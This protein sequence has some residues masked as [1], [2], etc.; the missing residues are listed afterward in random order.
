MSSFPIEPRV[1]SSWAKAQGFAY[2]FAYHGPSM[3]P[4]FRSGDLLYLR[5]G[6]KNLLPGDVI[7]FTASKES[8]YIVH[9]IV[10]RSDQGFI[11]RGDHNRLPDTSQ[12]TLEQV[13]GKVEFVENKQ[14]VRRVVNGFWGLW[15]ARF[16][17]LVFGLD[18]L[19]RRLFWVPYNFIRTRQIALVFWRPKISKMRVQ[20]ENGQQIKYLYNN[21]TVAVWDLSRQ[22]FDCRKPFDLVIPS[23]LNEKRSS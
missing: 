15:L 23:P 20:S 7:V 17:Q 19:L 6:V 10:A 5:A 14:G 1:L 13:V 2:C 4:T 16:W 18:R 3:V 22:R 8:D 11:T 21:R 12:V 9:R